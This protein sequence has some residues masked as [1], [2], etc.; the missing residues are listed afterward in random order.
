MGLSLDGFDDVL[1]SCPITAILR[2]AP[3]SLSA[4]RGAG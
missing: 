4:A 3:G 2:K 1:Q